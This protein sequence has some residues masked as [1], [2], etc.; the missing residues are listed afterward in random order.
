MSI[1]LYVWL[2]VIIAVDVVAIIG[3][4]ILRED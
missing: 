1:Y 2:G 3:Y 4:I